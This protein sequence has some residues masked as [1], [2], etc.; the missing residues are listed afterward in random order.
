MKYTL[1]QLE[2]LV[3]DH[4][5]GALAMLASARP[6]L[7]NGPVCLPPSRADV[8]STLPGYSLGSWRGFLSLRSVPKYDLV[9]SALSPNPNG[10]IAAVFSV[11]DNAALLAG[12]TSS[13]LP[14]ALCVGVNYTQ[15]K[16]FGGSQPLVDKT[17]MYPKATQAI[18]KAI[19]GSTGQF[20]LVA[21]NFFPWVTVGIWSHATDASGKHEINSLHEMLLLETCGF[22][23]PVSHV[24]SLA[25]IL[26]PQ[27]LLFH[28]VDNCVPSLGNT[29]RKLLCREAI[30]CDNISTR[31]QGKNEI[32]F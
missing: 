32:T 8:P 3:G 2:S 13:E 27:W 20:H 18:S 19:G 28:G 4:N 5:A 17:Y 1:A 23:D 26:R 14:V 15:W 12:E 29:V 7:F 6:A 25:E 31:Y 10:Q 9:R 11:V 21:A 16:S 30:F 22:D 24:R